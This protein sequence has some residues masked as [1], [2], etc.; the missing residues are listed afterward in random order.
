MNAVEKKNTTFVILKL[1]SFITG[2][3][4]QRKKELFWG[5]L[6]AQFLKWSW[7][8]LPHLHLYTN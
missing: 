1:W 5:I 3:L 7:I 6:W 2:V 4:F 8:I